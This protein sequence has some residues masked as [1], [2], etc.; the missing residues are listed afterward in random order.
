MIFIG[1]SIRTIHIDIRRQ[2][3][4]GIGTVGIIRPPS[5][6]VLSATKDSSTM[7]DDVVSLA[8]YVMVYVGISR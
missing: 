6:S 5:L 3:A 7:L 2:S 8:S 1:V 4:C